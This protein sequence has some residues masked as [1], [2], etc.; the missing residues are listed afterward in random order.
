VPTTSSTPY[1]GPISIGT[2]TT[3]KAIAS[4]ADYSESAVATGVYTINSPAATPT[5]SPVPG[6]YGPAQTVTISDTSPGATIYYTLDG[7]T[8]TTNSTQYTAPL[9]ISVTTTIKAIASGAGCSDSAIAT[10]TYTINGPAATPTFSPASGTYTSPQSVTISDSTAGAAVYYTLDGSLPST[11]STPY[12]GPITIDTTTTVKAIAS[13]SGYNLS[14][15]ASAAYT[16]NIPPALINPGEMT[17]VIGQTQ[18]IQMLNGDGS[19]IAGASWTVDDTSIAETG[20]DDS[21]APIVTAK[22]AGQ[23]TLHGISGNQAGQ[24]IIKVI[25]LAEGES[26]P[27]GTKL[28]VAPPLSGGTGVS[29]I[30][31]ARRVSDNTPAFYVQEDGPFGGGNVIRAFTADGLQKWSWR[32]DDARIVAGDN[33]G[34]VLVVN[35]HY[36]NA[37]T[38]LLL[39]NE[40]A[41][42]AW[43]VSGQEVDDAPGQ[44]AIRQDGT[45]FLLKRTSPSDAGRIVGLRPDNGQEALSV[46]LP[47]SYSVTIGIRGYEHPVNHNIYTICDPNYSNQQAGAGDV[48]PFAIDGESAFY[49]AVVANV[50]T[51][52]VSCTPQYDNDGYPLPWDGTGASNSV[53]SN[54]SL[55]KIDATGAPTTTPIDSSQTGEFDVSL[56][57]TALV[58]DGA[59]G[60]LFAAR[61]PDSSTVIYRSNATQFPALMDRVYRILLGEN[62]TLFVSGNGAA[63]ISLADGTPTWQIFGFFRLVA[64][65]SDGSAIVEQQSSGNLL[66]IDMSGVSS[67]LFDVAAPLSEATYYS[68]GAWAGISGESLGSIHGQT[69]YLSATGYAEPGLNP[70]SSNSKRTRDFELA[71]ENTWYFYVDYPQEDPNTEVGLTAQQ[72]D[73]IKTAALNAFKAA[74]STYRVDVGMGHQGT[75]T[76]YVSMGKYEPEPGTCAAGYTQQLWTDHSL[77]YYECN[78]TG[79]Q[80]INSG[81]LSTATLTAIGTGIG[82]TAAHELGHQFSLPQMDDQT[83]RTYNSDILNDATRYDGS[84]RTWESGADAR[85]KQILGTK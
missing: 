5:F 52:T 62:G 7:S 27:A 79:A 33:N 64:A 51:M 13:A 73:T 59:G 56:W 39:L 8:P 23:T 2:T 3:L 18:H 15:I 80:A 81:T 41:Q 42:S 1:S 47:P 69:Q 75:N 78:M 44:H 9:T 60:A 10:G 12:S 77:V 20:T 66:R 25:Y 83:I 54:L 46:S 63:A 84:P 72:I 68:F 45:I 6:A 32:G 71:W 70:Q 21:G 35:Y 43:G 40:A 50:E 11:G 24:A 58:P 36:T 38:D 17:L 67:A 14:D 29:K 16:I 22:A 76:V 57:A 28:W 31:Q 37:P 26:L 4:A 19:P 55:L 74:F 61:K 49:A 53:T 82:N 30:V 34:N 85:L 65:L 48:S